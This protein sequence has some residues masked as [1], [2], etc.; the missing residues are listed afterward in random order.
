MSIYRINSTL[1]Q[2]KEQIG[3][4]KE[5][6]PKIGAL[7]ETTY[8]ALNQLWQTSNLNSTNYRLEKF[9]G[10]SIDDGSNE[11]FTFS[12]YLLKHVHQ[13]SEKSETNET[14]PKSPSRVVR[15]LS[16]RRTAHEQLKRLD[17]ERQAA[18]KKC[19]IRVQ[20]Y[21]N[22]ILVC[23]TEEVSLNWDFTANFSQVYNL[24]VYEQPETVMLIVSE[25]FDRNTWR[26]LTKIYVPFV[27]S[28]QEFEAQL[29]EPMEF[30]SQLQI[31]AFRNSIGCGEIPRSPHLSGKLYCNAVWIEGNMGQTSREVNNFTIVYLCIF[32]FKACYFSRIKWPI[33]THSR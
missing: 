18:I 33:K 29:L 22:D 15:A 24:K 12:T 5:E 26:D 30:A 32:K 1:V 9:S 4:L 7:L 17:E 23:K 3:A 27:L 11:E 6:M 25:K 28:G 19:R 14:E 31:H 10:T 2:L 13:K 8:K 21:F 16:Q 20:I